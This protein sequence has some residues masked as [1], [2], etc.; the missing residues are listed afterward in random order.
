MK[1]IFI[2]ISLILSSIHPFTRSTVT[3]QTYVWKGGHVLV[4]NPD[5]I[6]FVKPDQGLQVYDSVANEAHI[7]YMFTYLTTDHAGK[8][9]VMSAVLYLP[10]AQR[11]SKH[12][13][14][15]ALYNHYTIMSSHEAPSACSEEAFDLQAIALG[16]GMAVVAADYEG[17]GVTGDRVQA[18]CFGEAN[19]RASIDALLAARE[20]LAEQGYTLGDTILNYGYS[21]GGQTSMAALKLSQ[22]EY[23]GKVHF[24]KTVA[25]AGPYDLRLTYRKFLEWQKIG[26]PAVLP[27]TLVTFNEL[28]DLGINYKDVFIEPL[29]SN[30]KSWIISKKFT[31]DEFRQLVN[32][33]SIAKYMQPLYCDSTTTEM[34]YVLD[35]VD[36]MRITGDWTPDADTDVKLYHS[37]NDDIVAP[38][39]SQ[40]MYQWLLSK[41]V[42]NAVLDTSSLTGLHTQSG[43]YFLLYV[44]SIDLMGW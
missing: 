6:T 12:I 22:T 13:G 43:Q 1:R 32:N 5:S 29:A 42:Q 35:Y 25:G 10:Y 20:W 26:Q 9:C 17:F 14:K 4:E 40:M 24:T 27:M 34:E 2:I 39:N 19:A 30:V 23:R 38:E 28:Y 33:D 21:Q 37:L 44:M 18:Y 8:P 7:D 16:K 31:T 15:M 41:G 3:A 11:S 36:R